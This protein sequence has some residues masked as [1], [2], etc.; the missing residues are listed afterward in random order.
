VGPTLEDLFEE[1]E[2][3]M[4]R[5]TGKDLDPRYVQLFLLEQG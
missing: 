2:N 3:E 1:I 4:D 5:V